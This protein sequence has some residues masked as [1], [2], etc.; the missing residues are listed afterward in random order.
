MHT[1]LIFF[2]QKEKKFKSKNHVTLN[3]FHQILRKAASKFRNSQNLPYNQN[4]KVF[5]KNKRYFLCKKY[6]FP[7]ERRRFLFFKEVEN[8]FK[9]FSFEKV[10]LRLLI[11][12]C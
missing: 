12:Y 1:I 11:F 9:L 3:F 7:L 8:L 5:Q 10:L 2:I 4:R 6:I